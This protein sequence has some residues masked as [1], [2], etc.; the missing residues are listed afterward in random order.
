VSLKSTLGL[1]WFDLAIHVGVTITLM[2][3]ADSAST[4]PGNEGVISMVVATSLV[5]LAW[6]RARAIRKGVV[7]GS[8]EYQAERVV[9]LEHRVADLE[10]QQG[11]MIDLEERLDFTERLLTQQ[12]ERDAAR[13]PGA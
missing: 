11:R 8:G 6:R 2:I 13:L 10:A 4:G 1:D 9:D 12:R 7:T 3:V 5:V